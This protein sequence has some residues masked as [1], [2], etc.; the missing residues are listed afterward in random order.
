MTVVLAATVSMLI[1]AGPGCRQ[2]SSDS[3]T[4]AAGTN[5]ETYQ[6]TG[7]VKELKP[8]GKTAVIAHDEIPGYMDPMTMD[9]E[10]K[11]KRELADLRPGDR[12]AFTLVV[13]PNDAWIEHTRK[14]PPQ[15]TNTVTQI[16]PT[17]SA[18]LKMRKSPV[19]EPLEVG[20][21]V[22][23]YKFT[24]HLNEAIGLGQFRG[25]AV[26]I[27]FIF[28]RCPLPTYCPRM[29]GN[30]AA[31]AQQLKTS[32]VTNWT[33]LSIS[34]DPEWDTPA[35]LALYARQYNPDPRH[36]QFV[37]S[38]FW[39]LDG[40]TEQLGLQFW[41]DAGSINHNLRTAVIDARGRL[42]KVFVGNEWKPEEFAEEMSKAAKVQ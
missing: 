33:L 35:R 1:M 6:V 26:G 37:T 38:D 19:V 39:N 3:A 25:R 13:I 7:L 28:T 36:W 14:L 17:N 29:S 30:F 15:N 8:D 2:Q 27:T 18:P 9:F 34:F 22:P 4:A 24:N 32:G 16:I 41:K 31:T 20:D 11:D 40:I 5:R 21:A 10:A 42:H 23:D 12:I